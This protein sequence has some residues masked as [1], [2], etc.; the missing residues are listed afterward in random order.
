MT[1]LEKCPRTNKR[2]ILHVSDYTRDA[3]EIAA[4]HLQKPFL[5]LYQI[6]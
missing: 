6:I 3:S 4:F 1:F 2:N 5:R